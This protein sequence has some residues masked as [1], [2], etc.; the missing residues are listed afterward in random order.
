VITDVSPSVCGEDGPEIF[1]GHVRFAPREEL[2]ASIPPK[3]IVDSL[4]AT[5][6]EQPDQ[7][8]SKFFFPQL[9]V[10]EIQLI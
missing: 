5:Y 2:I 9:L 1:H 6:F 3:N 8:P 7:V 10:Q 4:V